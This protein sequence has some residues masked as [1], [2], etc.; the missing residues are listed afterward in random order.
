MENMSKSNEIFAMYG[1]LKEELIERKPQV[2]PKVEAIGDN[3][4]DNM[5]DELRRSV[6]VEVGQFVMALLNSHVGD[7]MYAY[8]IPQYDGFKDAFKIVMQRYQ[9]MDGTEQGDLFAKIENMFK[10]LFVEKYSSLGPEAA[11]LV[12]KKYTLQMVNYMKANAIQANVD[13]HQDKTRTVY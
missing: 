13:L 12:A 7:F 10:D 9:L 2:Q 3:T 5:M 8:S 1:Q 6:D 4:V 11:E